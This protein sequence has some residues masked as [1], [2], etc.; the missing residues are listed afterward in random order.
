MSRARIMGPA[1]VLTAIFASTLAGCGVPVDGEVHG[2]AADQIPYGL[3]ES[4]ATSTLVSTTAAA[5]PEVVGSVSAGTVEVVTLYF[6]ADGQLVG[7]QREV[8]RPVA[9]TDL[10][11]QLEEGPRIV[12]QPPGVRSVVRVEHIK[13]ISVR[14]GVGT[15]DLAPSFIQ[16]AP[17]E[18]RLAVAQLVL[19]LT[20]RPGIGQVIFSSD[21]QPLDV[22]RGDGSLLK[23]AVS[24]DDYIRLLQ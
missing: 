9:P 22:P 20:A 8:G 3:A 10:T 7:Q 24:R 11:T 6:V 2:F 18:R 17:A 19:T 12:D 13:A 1:L 14:A 16:L 5:P 4:S 23:G 21:G 15:V